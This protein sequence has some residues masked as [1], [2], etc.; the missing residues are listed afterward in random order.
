MPVNDAADNVN[1]RTLFS[2]VQGCI[3]EKKTTWVILKNL[4]QWN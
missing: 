3:R 2:R 1:E 4:L